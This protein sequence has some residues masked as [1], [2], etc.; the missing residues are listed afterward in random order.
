MDW[1]LSVRGLNTNFTKINSDLLKRTNVGMISLAKGV[2][3]KIS[4]HTAYDTLLI[5]T[6]TTANTGQS[7]LCGFYVVHGRRSDLAPLVT[8]IAQASNISITQDINSIIITNNSDS[9]AC[10]V[11]I[12]SADYVIVE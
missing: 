11:N 10:V 8:S 2:S 6:T 3:K 7:G 5:S 12:H 9:F 1:S 4:L